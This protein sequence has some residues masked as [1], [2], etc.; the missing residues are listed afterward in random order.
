MK[1]PDAIDLHRFFAPECDFSLGNCAAAEVEKRRAVPRTRGKR[2]IIAASRTSK[3]VR[4][5]V[6]AES[7]HVKSLGAH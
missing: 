7:K 6:V 2:N 3:E 1:I 4:G 5:E